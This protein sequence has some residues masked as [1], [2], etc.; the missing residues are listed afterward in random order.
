MVPGE[1]GRFDAELDEHH[2]L[3]HRMVGET[4]RYVAVDA[5]GEWLAL[6]GFASPALSCGPRDRFIGWSPEVQLRR[7]RFVA[8][9]QRFCI[10]PAGRRQNTASAVMA[11]TLR[12]ISPDWV[13]AWG[14]RVLLV[15]T[16][17]D[18]SRH[19]G[20]CYGASSFLHLGVTRGFGRRSGRYVAHGQVKH[21]YVR[22]L[23]R[24]S[25]EVLAGTFDHPLLADPRSAA[26][27]ARI[28]FNTADLT[29][30]IER[31]ETITD[32]RDPRG[33]RHDFA[34]TLVLIACATL[35]GNKSLVAIS[36]W[37]DGSSEEV[38]CRLGARISPASGLRIP[39]S[40]ATIRRATMAV[41]ADEFDR[42][43]N[44]WAGEQANRRGRNSAIGDGTTDDDAGGPSSTGST[45]DDNSDTTG[46]HLTGVAIDGK[47]VRGAR[48]D[49]GTQVQ[50]LAALRHDTG[51]V[52]G[53][54]NV[55]NDKTNEIVAFPVLIEPLDLT[56]RVVTADAMHTQK[57]AA[58]LV[59]GKGGHYVFGVK[60]NQ[61]KLWDAA[62]EAGSS[63]D[64]ERPEFETEHRGHGRI[65]RH[66]AWSVPVPVP[67]GTSFP[68]ASCFVIVERES[69][70]L[71]DARVSIETRFYVT[72]LGEADACVEHLLRLVRGH[73]SIE[74]LHW[75]RDNTFD[76]DRSQ[77]RTGTIPRVLATLR[78]LAIGI[79]R[80][81]TYRTVNI[82]AATRQLARQPD[83]TLDLLGIP[84]LLCK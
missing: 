33:V 44:T 28:D 7:L 74:S 42:I 27:V 84:P 71:D 18:P 8:S 31:I 10:L 76:E 58:T 38:L 55:E 73:W 29:S 68:H 5:T 60:Q 6:V 3:G 41:D 20:T 67:E 77:V 36:E 64:N 47:A 2:W 23:H 30:L 15:E 25:T 13:E 4:M 59:V 65:D 51:M 1:A 37:C 24:R 62:I 75:V 79:I 17:V 9:N 66:R 45:P 34:S 26:S 35:A 43:V 46:A 19:L 40:Y 56:G 70:T 80:H 57:A 14:H 72:D 69:S 82:A 11:K 22:S 83:V 48:R 52:I 54:V 16:F 32:P 12:R 50:L 21:V 49:D 61:P 53:Q 63:I 81:T 39:P 78:N